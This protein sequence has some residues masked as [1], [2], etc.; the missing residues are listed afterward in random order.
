MGQMP[1]DRPPDE[2]VRKGTA[3]R[4]RHI[5][6][7]FFRKTGDAAHPKAKRPQR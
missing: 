4:N 6:S 7:V 3:N 5:P 2:S 1:S